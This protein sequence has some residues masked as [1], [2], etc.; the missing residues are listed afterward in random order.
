MRY[1]IAVAA[2]GAAVYGLHRLLLWA[3]ERDWIYYGEHQRKPGG[4]FNFLASIYQP[5]MEH[6][7]EEQQRVRVMAEDQEVGEGDPPGDTSSDA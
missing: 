4:N 2:L 7:I 6:V 1:L 3:A 5:S